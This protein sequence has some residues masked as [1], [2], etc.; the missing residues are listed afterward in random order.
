MDMATMWKAYIFGLL[1][2]PEPFDK[3]TGHIL[4]S[5]YPV[6]NIYM[7]NMNLL[8]TCYVYTVRRLAWGHVLIES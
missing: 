8:M 1:C 6:T 7:S 2:V 4:L 5:S 3:Q